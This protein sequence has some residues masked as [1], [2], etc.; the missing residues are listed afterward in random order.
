LEKFCGNV[1]LNWFGFVPKRGPIG[2][3]KFFPWFAVDGRKFDVPWRAVPVDC[4]EPDRPPGPASVDRINKLHSAA[5]KIVLIKRRMWTCIVFPLTLKARA[6]LPSSLATAVL[7]AL[8]RWHSV[9]RRINPKWTRTF[10][11]FCVSRESA[12]VA[13]EFSGFQTV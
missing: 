2:R 12:A 11:L 13:A 9:I 6:R 8:V 3:V 7:C 1:L 5:T 10:D 4:E